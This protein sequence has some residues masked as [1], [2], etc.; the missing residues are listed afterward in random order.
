VIVVLQAQENRNQKRA[1]LSAAHSAALARV[2][3]RLR[4]S[5]AKHHALRYASDSI[6]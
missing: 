2:E 3:A 5:I 6:P 1:A 4:S